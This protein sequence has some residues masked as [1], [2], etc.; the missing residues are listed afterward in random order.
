[1]ARKEK[2]EYCQKI[3]QWA[4]ACCTDLPDDSESKKEWRANFRKH[5]AFMRLAAS[6]SNLLG[7]LVY[8][9]QDV[10]T[11]MCPTHKGHWSGLDDG[12]CKCGHT[13]WLP[14]ATPES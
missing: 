7:R 1:M 11:E 10:R 4:E 8:G 13:G 2:Q 14:N 3:G 9:E 12:S 6:K 5:W